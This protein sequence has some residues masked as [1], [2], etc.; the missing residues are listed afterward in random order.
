MREGKGT[1][2]ERVGREKTKRERETSDNP[3]NGVTSWAG[4][5]RPKVGN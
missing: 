1:T 2:R 4:M 3:G 5:R